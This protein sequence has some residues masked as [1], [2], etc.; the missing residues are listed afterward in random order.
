[1]WAPLSAHVRPRAGG[2]TE[3]DEAARRLVG[4]ACAAHTTLWT[5]SRWAE[6]PRGFL[7]AQATV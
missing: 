1:M 4:P 7:W 2:G 6:R 3:D 5:P